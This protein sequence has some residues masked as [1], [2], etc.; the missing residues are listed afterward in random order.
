MVIKGR[1]ECNI[2]RR[3]FVKELDLQHEFHNIGMGLIREMTRNMKE[4]RSGHRD[5]AVVP[6]P[7][8]TLGCK[9]FH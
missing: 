7:Y 5:G 8:A 4:N 6:R 3:E 9:L 1:V 2:C